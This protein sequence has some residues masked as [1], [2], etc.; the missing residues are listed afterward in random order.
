M[1]DSSISTLARKLVSAFFINNGLGRIK[2]K[3]ES[4]KPSAVSSPPVII[5]PFGPRIVMGMVGVL[6]AV[7]MSGI[8]DHV[9][10]IAMMDI[11]GGLQ[12][13]H[14]EGS[15]LKALFQ[16]G[17]VVGMA[18]A[19]WCAVTFTLR[20][21]CLVMTSLLA[22]LG[23]CCPFAP[24][25][26]TLYFLR[27]FQGLAGGFLPPLLIT[28]ALRYCPPGIR[29]FGFAG[30]ALS[31]TFGPNMATPLAAWWS[32]YAGTAWIFWHI[33]PFCLISLVAVFLGLPQDKLRLDR[34]K[35]FDWPGLILGAPSIAALVIAVHQADRLNWLES[36][37]ITL[38][39]LAGGITFCL[40]LVHEWFYKDPI[41]KL[42]ILLRRNFLFS[43]LTIAG[44]LILY[45]GAIVVPLV[46]LGEVKGY[47]PAEVVGLALIIAMPQLIFLPMV[48]AILN[49][50]RVDARWVFACGISILSYSF[51]LSTDLTSDWV[52]TDFYFVLM[53]QALGQPL[54][55]LPIL[56]IVVA[57]MPAADGPYISAMFNAT[58]GFS[59]VLITTLVEGFG[60][61]RM[62][63]HSS[64]LTSQLGRNSAALYERMGVFDAS[65]N[66]L[67]G[68]SITSHFSLELV[69]EQIKLQS[70]TL[71]MADVYQV[72]L[73]IALALLILVAILP[74]RV[75]PP[76][77]VQ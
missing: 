46:F 15:W 75:Y 22:I 16:A 3:L 71:A 77:P 40:F 55:I 38:L 9:T 30:Y 23:F 41:F 70:L 12:I 62:D 4:K 43:T 49:I 67:I 11:Q 24:N 32:D 47:R 65:L 13:G 36:P 27:A 34:W 17:Q 61:I 19:P 60:H 7:M 8:N 45:L 53:L 18:F 26:E 5:P 2:T 52:Q 1:L 73:V 54:T 58:K 64:V 76:W 6:I 20:R 72:L 14:D 50:K 31:S 59:A 29:L 42:Q 25:I 69:A 39:A 74:T 37:L 51:Y 44:L 56:M 57:D 21:F 63:Y 68:K 33:I 66:S 28:V 10:D 35:T 48:S